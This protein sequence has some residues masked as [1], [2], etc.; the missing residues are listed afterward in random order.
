[1][2]YEVQLSYPAYLPPSPYVSAPNDVLGYP[3]DIVDVD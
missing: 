2:D 3:D 1:M